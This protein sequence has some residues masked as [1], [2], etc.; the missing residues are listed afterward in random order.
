MLEGLTPD[1]GTTVRIYR[2]GKTYRDLELINECSPADFKPMM[3]AHPP[4]N[5]GT[6]RVH[7]RSN[8]GIVINR[9][10]K[11]AAAPTV[12]TPGVTQQGQPVAQIQGGGNIDALAMMFA[13]MQEASDARMEALIR[14]IAPATNSRKDVMEEMAAMATI[15]KSNA[16]PVVQGDDFNKT[17]N[18]VSAILAVSEKLRP[19]AVI[20]ADGQVSETAALFG[21]AKEVFTTARET[22]ATQRAQLAQQ[23]ALPAPDAPLDDEAIEMN[24]MQNM[25]KMQLRRACKIAAANGDP[26]DYADSIYDM[27]PE[28]ELESFA[29]DPEWFAKLVALE[30]GC[31][32][33]EAWFKL[34]RDSLV[35]EP[36]PE[37]PAGPP[38]EPCEHVWSV[39]E[40]KE[41]GQCVK[42]GE[43]ATAAV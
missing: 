42:C 33:H 36:A 39:G 18:A 26:V 17:I 35:E 30:P 11:V 6:F 27:L 10:L 24:L 32:A 43:P 34:V 16:P 15:I 1:D 37:V 23:P 2:Q 4:Y 19:A 38:A 25:F 28:S 20:G 12:T 21:M 5:G 9:E 41:P 31:A 22:A 29:T 40:G 8:G 7:A 3:L 14:A 13:K